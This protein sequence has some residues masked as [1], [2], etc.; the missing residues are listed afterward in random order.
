MTAPNHAAPLSTW[1][2]LD[3]QVK[4]YSDLPRRDWQE[5]WDAVSLPA[6]REL[7]VRQS[8]LPAPTAVAEVMPLMGRDARVRWTEQDLWVDEALHLKLGGAVN[9]LTLGQ[10]DVPADALALAMTELHRAGGWV[11]L[12]ACVVA[13]AGHAVAITGPSGAGKSTALL[14]LLQ[15]GYDVIAE[16]RSFWHAPTGRI[17]GMDRTLRA[18]TRSLELFA[19]AWLPR[20]PLAQDQKGKWLLP[21]EELRSASDGPATLR[22]VLLLGAPSTLERG[23][24]V[25]SVWEAT[26]RPLLRQ[27][28]QGTQAGVHQLIHQVGIQG[29]D[30]ETAMTAVR[31]ILQQDSQ[32]EEDASD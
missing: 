7:I 13:R 21:L 14:R 8:V 10:D 12:H 27:G 1:V 19:P 16:D 29:V 6:R 23:A 17:V 4:E 22:R 26:G 11:P 25:R 28:L 30:R 31:A 20:L 24:C 9:V 3:V 15:E 5:F 18:Y 32:I 2:S